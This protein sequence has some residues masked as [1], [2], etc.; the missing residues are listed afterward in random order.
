MEELSAAQ[1]RRKR[2]D[3]KMSPTTGK[4]FLGGS[5]FAVLQRAFP[6]I[7]RGLVLL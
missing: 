4:A 3:L 1:N 7:A 2:V 6:P 5:N